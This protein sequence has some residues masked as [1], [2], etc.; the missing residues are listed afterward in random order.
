MS[1]PFLLEIGTE[2]IPDWMIPGALENLRAAVREAGRSRTNRVSMDATPRRLVL[3]AEGLPERQPDSEERVLGPAK[4]APAAGRGRLR[5]QAGREARRPEHR[6]H[7]QGRILQFPQEGGRPPDQGHPGRS[8]A[9]HHPAD[10]LPQDDVLDRQER[11][12]L[13]PAHPLDRGAAG[14]RIVPFEIAGVRSRCADQRPSPPGRARDRGHHRRLRAAAARSLRDPLR[15]RAAQE[16][17]QRTGRRAASSP[18]PRCSKPWS[19]SPSTPP[20]SPAASTRSSSNCPKRC[21]SP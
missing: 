15:R 21:W 1:L 5:A 16:D 17:S 11:P 2:E 10:L 4:S 12:A 13:H 6:D 18:M 8:A 3:R 7:A 9:R 19:T 14:R 20:P